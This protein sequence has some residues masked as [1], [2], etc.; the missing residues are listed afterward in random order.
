MIKKLIIGS[1]SFLLTLIFWVNVMGGPSNFNLLPYEIYYYFAPNGN[2]ES[3]FIYVFD[4]VVG[5][6][7]FLVTYKVFSKIPFRK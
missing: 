2:N 5:L 3:K 1:I 7:I 4:G 6:G